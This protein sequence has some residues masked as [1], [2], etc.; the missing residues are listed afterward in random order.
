M[1]ANEYEIRV[2]NQG[3]IAKELERENYIYAYKRQINMNIMQN[4]VVVTCYHNN[5]YKYIV[6]FTSNIG[7]VKKLTEIVVRTKQVHDPFYIICE[8]IEAMQD[9]I[10]EQVGYEKTPDSVYRLD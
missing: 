5:P 10:Y 8:T 4:R 2:R 1:S 3:Y 9:Y 6:Q 7:G